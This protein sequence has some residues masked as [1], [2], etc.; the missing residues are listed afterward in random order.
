MS[1]KCRSFRCPSSSQN[2]TWLGGARGD[3]KAFSSTSCIISVG[4]NWRWN[5]RL[6]IQG[7]AW[8][9]GIDSACRPA[10][11]LDLA[12][13]PFSRPGPRASAQVRAH[14]LARSVTGHFHSRPPASQIGHDADRAL[15]T[16]DNPNTSSLTFAA[17]PR[18]VKKCSV[19]SWVLSFIVPRPYLSTF[20]HHGRLENCR[21]C[22]VATSLPLLLPPPHPD[23][24]LARRMH[25][26]RRSSAYF[27]LQPPYTSMYL[28]SASL[29]RSPSPAPTFLIILLVIP[30]VRC[31][32]LAPRVTLKPSTSAEVGMG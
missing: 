4:Y 19:I 28:Q 30:A 18:S 17:P 21:N 6:A 8:I 29:T 31:S 9:G 1:P 7:G 2:D 27:R 25:Y 26:W 32:S 14:S 15:E 3:A 11:L 20:L 5:L 13:R 23:K 10:E 12:F 16:P 22:V 24:T